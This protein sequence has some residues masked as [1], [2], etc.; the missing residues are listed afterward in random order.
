MLVPFDRMLRVARKHR[1]AVGAFNIYNL[2]GALAV[3]RA[4]EAMDSPVII[5]LLPSALAPAGTPLIH[6]CL[7][8]GR[9]ASVPVTLHLDHCP[10]R[11]VI[12]MAL[13]AGISSVM[14]DGSRLDYG[15]NIAFT[16]MIVGEAR[17]HGAFVEGE[18]GRLSG[19][20]D[21]FTVASREE[22]MTRPRQAAN[23]TEQTRISA[24]AV[25]IGN[26][27]GPYRSDP[28]L[29]FERLAAIAAMVSI[30][31]V[32]HGTSGLPDQMISKAVAHGVCKFN[33]N[34]EI[35]QA[36]TETLSRL[37]QKGET[38]ELVTVMEEC[39]DAM[40][41]PIQE[42]ITLFGSTRKADLYT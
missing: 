17:R 3:V 2:E 6:L 16:K 1:F 14:A 21:G 37:F 41:R 34:T 11:Q 30:P 35:R 28:L 22:K 5:Q 33:V 24:L 32:L 25:C 42:K 39:I 29:D 27:H 38:P 31:L 20:E 19:S 12:G 13:T 23:F 15:D 10:D 8:A 7:E 26:V 40:K 9:N 18:L 4:A 36:Y